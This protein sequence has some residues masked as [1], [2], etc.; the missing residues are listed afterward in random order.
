MADYNTLNYTEQGGAVT[1]IGGKLKFAAGAQIEGGIIANQGAS[2][3]TS[4]ADLKAD[5]NSLLS[6][7]K[8]SGLMAADTTD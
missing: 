4:I 6:K 7:L 3:A 8:E 2:T 5:L 1:V